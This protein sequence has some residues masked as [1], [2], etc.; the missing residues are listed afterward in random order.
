MVKYTGKLAP[1]IQKPIQHIWL[2]KLMYAAT[3]PP[4]VIEIVETDLHK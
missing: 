1:V 3:I 4:S 2:F